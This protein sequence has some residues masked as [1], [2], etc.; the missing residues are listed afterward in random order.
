MRGSAFDP[1]RKVAYAI[2]AQRIDPLYALGFANRADLQMLSEID[3]LSG[4]MSVFRLVGDKKFLLAVGQ[5]NSDTC[6]GFQDA[7]TAAGAPPR[8]RSA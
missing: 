3:G 2:T 7:G 8:W 6:T 5:D 1:D 4:D